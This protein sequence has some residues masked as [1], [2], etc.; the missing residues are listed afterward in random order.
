MADSV[1]IARPY[2]EAAFRLARESNTL[3]KW[4]QMLDVL[5]G[6]ARDPRVGAY[7]RDPKVSGAQLEATLLG[8]CGEQLDGAG[9]N[10]V[11][12][13]VRNARLALLPEMRELFEQLKLEHEGVLEAQIYSAFAMD[14]SQ[15]DQLVAKLESKYSRKVRAQVD[16]DPELIGGVKIIVGDN[17]LDVTV[18]GKLDEMS[19]VLTR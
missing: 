4:S 10:F 3:A 17:V 8:L 9:R 2:A 6:V 13:L 19:S 1:T 15:I 11:Q 18:R 14:A 7:I 16:I 12:V 5:A